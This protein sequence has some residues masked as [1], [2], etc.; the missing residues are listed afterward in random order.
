MLNYSSSFI[1]DF[2]RRIAPLVELLSSSSNNQWTLVHT[3]A[4]NYLASIVWQHMKLVLIDPNLPVEIHVDA[5]EEYCSVILMQKVGGKPVVN[6]L[7]G[8]K[9]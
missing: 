4:L 3:E 7:A 5:D 1:P 2:K 6:A 8:R 9:L